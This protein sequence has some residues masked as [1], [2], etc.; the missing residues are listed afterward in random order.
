MEG[1]MSRS[2]KI[3]T[4]LF[5]AMTPLLVTNS[6]MAA[7]PIKVGGLFALS[8]PAAH[9]GIA[10]KNSCKLIF[11][12][13][14]DAGG[15]DGRMIEFIEADTEGDPTKTLLKTKWL[16]EEQEVAVIIGPTRTGSGMAIKKY[17]DEAKVPAF[18][19]AGSDV[20]I[21]APPVYWFFKSPY[22]TTAALGKVFEYVKGQG[23][24][25][26]AFMYASDGFGKDG[27]KNAQKLAP[28][29]GIDIVAEE[30]FAPKDVDM[31]AQLTKIKGTDAQ[32]IVCWTIGPAGGIVA[33][34]KKQLGMDQ[35]L[36][37]CHGQAEPIFIKVAGDAAEG[38]MMPATK[39]Y[40]GEELE[41]SDPQKEKILGFVAAYTPLYGPPGVM[42]S[43]GADAAYIVV[44]AL[45]VAGDDRAKIRD[46]IEN[47]QG[48]IGL[49]GIY[50]MSPE[51]HNGLTIKDVVMLKVENGKFRLV[52]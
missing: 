7:E 39:I 13:V 42:V 2:I 28:E 52:K 48:Y 8:G 25:K 24:D 15:I 32:A 38:V 27:V 17:V 20:I 21:T 40:V 1:D 19:H 43:Y 37:Q 6:V 16:I 26:I 18:L 30:A 10:L 45:K 34:N 47:I 35:P 11:D 31:T 46:A 3:L 9:I 50:N 12:Q 33:K 41:D 29:F 4:V 22:K 51:D 49:S 14:N 23:M 44:E 5:L 36:F